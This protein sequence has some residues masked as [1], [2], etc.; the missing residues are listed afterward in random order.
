MQTENEGI[1]TQFWV[2]GFAP[3]GQEKHKQLGI[4]CEQ[5]MRDKRLSMSAKAL[6]IGMGVLTEMRPKVVV[7]WKKIFE[8]LN[9]SRGTL[10]WGPG[11]I[12]ERGI[13]PILE[14]QQYGYL[15][16]EAAAEN[17]VMHAWTVHVIPNPNLR[18][19]K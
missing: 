7:G 10:Q 13:P 12:E 5:V 17:A 3:I 14:A 6:I 1:Q 15:E 19:A 11:R 4:L 9:T 16:Q 18:N 8:L 2:N